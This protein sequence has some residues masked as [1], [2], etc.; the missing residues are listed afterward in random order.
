MREVS[1]TRTGCR[2]ERRGRP[3]A[4]LVALAALVFGV[5]AAYAVD[6]TQLPDPALQE[7]YRALTHELRC[8]QCQNE[9]IADSPV[10]LAADLRR[11][12]RDML[13]AGKSD[14]DVRNFMVARYGDF[15]LFRPRFNARNA[16]LW[17]A[18]GVLLLVGALVFVRVVQRRSALVSEDN[19]PLEEDART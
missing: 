10:S 9:A 6:P 15:I 17:M 14:E 11:E 5:T 19:E 4:C 12:V 1:L 18:P 16:W 2:R 7:R 13:L 8:M 3:V